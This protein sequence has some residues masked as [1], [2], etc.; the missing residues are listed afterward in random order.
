MSGLRKKIR[1]S[2]FQQTEQPTNILK[3]ATSLEKNASL[4][5]NQTELPSN[6]IFYKKVK[7]RY[8]GINNYIFCVELLNEFYF[9]DWPFFIKDLTSVDS[10]S[11]QKVA[12]TSSLL[13]V[14]N[15]DVMSENVGHL[16]YFQPRL[17]Y[18]NIFKPKPEN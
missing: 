14:P 16:Q 5:N 13:Q 12:L 15:F 18:L 7:F 10:K 4:H 8:F 11:K 9:I 2:F 17:A 1:K 6:E 3:T